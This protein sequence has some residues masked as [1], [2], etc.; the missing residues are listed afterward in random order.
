MNKVILT[1]YV[2]MVDEE[3]RQAFCRIDQKKQPLFCELQQ[4][5]LKLMKAGTTVILQAELR[6]R[7]IV[8]RNPCDCNTTSGGVESYL[9]VQKVF[10]SEVYCNEAMLDPVIAVQP[11]KLIQVSGKAFQSVRVRLPDTAGYATVTIPNTEIIPTGTEF[12]VRGV[13]KAK[14]YEKH[15]VCPCCKQEH[16]CT[17]LSLLVR[18]YLEK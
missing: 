11:G 1:A 13:I 15:A 6:S 10:L 18:G 3:K 17:Q 4:E 7:D 8:T 14:E 9:A 5:H 2:L 16:V 12:S